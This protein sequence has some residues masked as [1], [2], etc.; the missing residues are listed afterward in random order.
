M[1]IL[2]SLMIAFVLGYSAE[3]EGYYMTHK[4][5]KGQQSIVKFFKKGEKYYC[6]GF[7]NVDGSAPKKDVHNPNIA[8]RERYDRGAV[9]VY[10]LKREG[11][12]DI[13]SN[14]KVYN[15]DSG[16]IYYAKITLKG[17]SLEL[18]GSIDSKGIIGETKIWRK[19]DKAEVA[20]YLSQEPD[21]SIVES[22]LKDLPQD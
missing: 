20:P 3:L 10:N 6:Y 14:G 2:V 22:S 11:S 5:Q 1:R 21:F 16:E 4:G 9:F 12:S 18:R 13:F 19:L 17:D 8:L 7:A 15:F